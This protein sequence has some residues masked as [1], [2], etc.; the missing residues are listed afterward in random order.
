MKNRDNLFYVEGGS[1]YDIRH[2]TMIDN[3]AVVYDKQLGL[4]MKYGD[5][6]RSDIREYYE[7]A[8][9]KLKDAGLDDDADNAILIEFDR[10]S[11]KLS[12]EE[13]CTVAN[14]I[15]S[16]SCLGTKLMDLL[17]SDEAVIRSKIKELAEA[18]F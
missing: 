9:N 2:S 3:L 6:E 12:I 7:R 10:Y 8:V 16:V 11:G 18:G 4:S 1:L 13:I 5:A 14:W 17:G 15:L